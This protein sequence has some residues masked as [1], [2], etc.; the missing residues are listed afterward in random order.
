MR[1]EPKKERTPR[2]DWA[3]R[4]C[5]S[6]ALG[7]TFL[8]SV[9]RP[10]PG[11]GYMTA[12]G[13][14]RHIGAPRTGHAACEAGSSTW[15]N[16]AGVVLSPSSS[17]PQT[18]A[19]CHAHHGGRLGQECAPRGLHHLSTGLAHTPIGTR[20]RLSSSP[21]HPPATFNRA[22][23]FPRRRCHHQGDHEMRICRPKRGSARCRNST[24]P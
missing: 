5:R 2:L 15:A 19:S 14:V 21:V 10:T 23:F 20:Q 9:R 7:C 24:G 13:I 17:G 6:L 4:L 1:A 22:P 18:Q 16:S 12:S 3:G 8:S 11:A